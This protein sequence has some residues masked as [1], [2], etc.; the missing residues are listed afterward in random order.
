MGI[1]IKFYNLDTF[2]KQVDANCIDLDSEF[3][4]LNYKVA[5]LIFCHF[6]RSIRGPD[7]ELKK[8][9]CHIDV[10]NVWYWGDQ[11]VSNKSHGQIFVEED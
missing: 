7:Y 5:S 6:W 4:D 11:T 1:E 9:K 2:K 10:R 3:V 8:V